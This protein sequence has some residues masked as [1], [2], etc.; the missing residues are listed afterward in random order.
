MINKELLT[1]ILF[2]DIETAPKWKS[3]EDVPE[4]FH[5]GIKKKFEKQE[6]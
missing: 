5:L 6:K 4:R 1:S 3:F 2:F